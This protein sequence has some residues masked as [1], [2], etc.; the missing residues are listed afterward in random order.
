MV[1]PLWGQPSLEDIFGERQARD[2]AFSR[3]L[4]GSFPMPSSGVAGQYLQSQRQPLEAGFTAARLLGEGNTGNFTDYLE[5]LSGAP[6]WGTGTAADRWATGP[7]AGR[8][9]QLA[10]RVGMNPQ[11]TGTMSPM[12]RAL[13]ANMRTPGGQSQ[14][15]NLGITPQ[16]QG[17]PM[18]LRQSFYDLAKDRYNQVLGEQG[19]DLGSFQFLPWLA[20]RQGNL[21]GANA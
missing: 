2:T 5:G 4:Q 14:Q 19:D 6:S 16:M 18:G 13:I 7:G 8:M 21:W 15:F 9:G 3:F 10:E 12:Q 11:A 20:Q 17:L 1:T